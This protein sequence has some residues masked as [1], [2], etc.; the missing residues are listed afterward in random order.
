MGNRWVYREVYG[1]GCRTKMGLIYS[2]IEDDV[3]KVYSVDIHFKSM[4]MVK[5]INK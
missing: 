3:T 1:D 4:V 5:K 2:L